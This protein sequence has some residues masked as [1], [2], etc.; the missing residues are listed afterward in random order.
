MVMVGVGTS[1]IAFI[2]GPQ[3]FFINTLRG[4][5]LWTRHLKGPSLSTAPGDQ[6]RDSWSPDINYALAAPAL[7]KRI[8]PSSTT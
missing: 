6:S 1:S 5:R 7:I 8:S 3:S 4:S 2:Y